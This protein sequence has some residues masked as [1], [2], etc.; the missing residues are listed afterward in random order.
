MDGVLAAVVALA[1]VGGALVAWR[2]WLLDKAEGR[3]QVVQVDQKAIDS[4]AGRI[5]AL[6]A[7]IKDL[8]WTKK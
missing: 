8:R 4:Y 3:K 5:S 6:E 1:G 2:W 7:E